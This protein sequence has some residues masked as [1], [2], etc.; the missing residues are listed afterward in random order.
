MSV[1]CLVLVESIVTI[2]INCYGI[3]ESLYLRAFLSF[4]LFGRPNVGA[5]LVNQAL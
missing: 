3:V 4:F 5:S 1:N 2:I